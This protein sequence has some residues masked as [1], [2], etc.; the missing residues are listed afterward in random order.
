MKL[1][2]ADQDHVYLKR[3]LTCTTDLEMLTSEIPETL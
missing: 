1:S 2:A 3:A